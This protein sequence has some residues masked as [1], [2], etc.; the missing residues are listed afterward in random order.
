MKRLFV[1]SFLLLSFLSFSQEW[2]KDTS[3]LNGPVK[4][5]YYGSTE[6]VTDI[7]DYWRYFDTKTEFNRSGKWIYYTNFL[8]GK[9][10]NT[11]I[12]I[13]DS[14]NGRHIFDFSLYEG[15]TTDIWQMIYNRKGRLIKEIHT[16][17][18][19]KDSSYFV[20]KK[21]LLIGKYDYQKS[22]SLQYFYNSKKTLIRKETTRINNDSG[23]TTKYF[24]FY[25]DKGR[26]IKDS[27]FSKTYVFSESQQ[28]DK[29]GRL[30]LKKSILYKA[31]ST[32]VIN[33]RNDE[34]PRTYWV[35]IDSKDERNGIITFEYNA[36]GQL[37]RTSNYF[38]D[39]KLRCEYFYEHNEKG[40]VSRETFKGSEEHHH[41]ETKFE[42]VY[43]THGNWILKYRF[44][45]EE[46]EY[47]TVEYR[48]I[49]YYD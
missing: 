10:F 5:V 25:D 27:T 11:K 23:D 36:L 16:K 19:Q 20:Y 40:L 28:Y 26:L 32:K 42:Y 38:L 37:V 22:Y 43:D 34:K 17:Y 29:N 9:E 15:D 4:A 12:R 24:K 35:P 13:Y 21:K 18:S 8:D 1:I 3:N 49:E 14:S 2:I 30:V 6:Y 44:D 7:T 31:P 39:G 46:L 48:K 33:F 47:F 41:S 45:I